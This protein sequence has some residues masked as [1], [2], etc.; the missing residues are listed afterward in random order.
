[1]RG[2]EQF[3][4]PSP[5]T[6]LSP[7]Y[8]GEGE[9]GSVKLRKHLGRR[10]AH[11]RTDQDEIERSSQLHWLRQSRRGQ[12]TTRPGVEKKNATSLPRR[13]G[14]VQRVFALVPAQFP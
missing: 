14:R 6:H 11:R 4:H 9:K 7:E 10:A 3:H 13:G 12:Y 5:P 2:L 1:V 8:R